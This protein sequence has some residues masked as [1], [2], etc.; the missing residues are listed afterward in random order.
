MML[1]RLG[2]SPRPFFLP[3]EHERDHFKEAAEKER[4]RTVLQCHEVETPQRQDERPDEKII[5][6]PSCELDKASTTSG[7]QSCNSLQ[8]CLLSI[9]FF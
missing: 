7:L 9:F 8:I 2:L 3:D 4:K 1:G 5:S 6:L